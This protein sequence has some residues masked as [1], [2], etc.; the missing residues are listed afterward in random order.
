M[1]ISIIEDEKILASKTEIKLKRNGFSVEVFNDIKSF[2]K[3][4]VFQSDLY[5]IDISLPDGDGLE[6]IQ[7]LREEKN[8]DSPIIITSGYG[9]KERKVYGL[10]I[11]AD[12]YLEKPYSPEEL[13]ARIR[14]AIRRGYKIKQSSKLYYKDVV[15]DLT[16]NKITKS[17]IEIELTS[18][19]MQF[20]EIM[21]YNAGKLIT[22]AQIINSV[23]GE[24]D[25]SLVSDNNVNVTISRVRKKLGDDFKLKTY[26][27]KGYILEK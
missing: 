9:D 18:R 7:W 16:K 4:L 20:V 19:E 17:G 23:W 26:I 24:Y 1:K 3:N 14:S 22:K 27:N 5:I 8:I 15:L 11:G 10:N 6:L 21:I 2:K 13:I 12:D 25:P